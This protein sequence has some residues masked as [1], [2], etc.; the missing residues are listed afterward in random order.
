MK[1]VKVNYNPTR[2]VLITNQHL[3]ELHT[4]AKNA[5]RDLA[6]YSIMWD[7]SAT[8][9]R[10]DAIRALYLAQ[11]AETTA[12]INRYRAYRDELNP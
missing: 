12:A 6:G 4:D 7:R 9:E 1:K 5:L 8:K 2:R 11:R 3:D 10:K